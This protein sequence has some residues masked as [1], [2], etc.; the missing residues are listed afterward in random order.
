MKVLDY[1]T[2]VIEMMSY[3]RN[4]FWGTVVILNL[5]IQDTQCREIGGKI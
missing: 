3:P 5:E 1:I 2:R 4:L